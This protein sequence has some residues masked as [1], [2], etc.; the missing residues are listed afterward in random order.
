VTLD[1]SDGSHMGA[2]F[3]AWRRVEIPSM[4]RADRIELW[5]ISYQYKSKDY[6]NSD[7]H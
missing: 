3:S 1:A 5:P 6:E 7:R 2:E 4:P